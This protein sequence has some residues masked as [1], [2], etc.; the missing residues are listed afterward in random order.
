MGLEANPLD[1]SKS[2]NISHTHKDLMS[3]G[4]GGE[5]PDMLFTQVAVD[6]T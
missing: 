1:L 5:K 6:S 3:S 2:K 4:S